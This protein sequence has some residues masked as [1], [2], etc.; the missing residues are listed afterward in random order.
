MA[1]ANSLAVPKVSDPATAS[2]SIW[3]AEV[4]PMA[5][6]LRMPIVT[7]LIPIVIKTTVPPCFSVRRNPSSTALAAAGSSSWVTPLRTMR[8]VLGSISIVTELAGIT[9]LQTITFNVHAPVNQNNG[10]RYDEGA[11]RIRRL[12][13]TENLPIIN[14]LATRLRQPFFDVALHDHVQYF[15]AIRDRLIDDFGI[16]FKMRHSRVHRAFQRLNELFELLI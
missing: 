2:S 1:A 16:V 3:T 7:S 5:R 8:L 10:L 12:V 15:L 9:L 6:A 11:I 14:S 4:A 13:D